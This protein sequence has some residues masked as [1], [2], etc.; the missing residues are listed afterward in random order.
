MDQD[1]QKT[2]QPMR[3]MFAI[4]YRRQRKLAIHTQ[5]HL[6]DLLTSL[7]QGLQAG[8]SLENEME[9]LKDTYENLSLPYKDM[10][11]PYLE[12]LESSLVR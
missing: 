3:I 12:D 2:E 11:A 1:S 8:I 7:I 4:E 5:I 9:K 6:L 10:L